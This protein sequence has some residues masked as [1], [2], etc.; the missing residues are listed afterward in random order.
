MGNPPSQP[1]SPQGLA[2]LECDGT[3]CPT[4]N[5]P[6]NVHTLLPEYVRTHRFAKNIKDSRLSPQIHFT[7]LSC[8]VCAVHKLRTVHNYNYVVEK[9]IYYIPW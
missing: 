5:T 4:C 8:H 9:T 7:V 6:A 1:P 3:G 2:N